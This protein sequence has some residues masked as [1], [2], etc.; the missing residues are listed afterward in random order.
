MQSLSHIAKFEVL[1]FFHGFQDE[2]IDNIHIYPYILL[3]ST[4]QI[5]L[6]HV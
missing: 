4:M 2:L 5:E 6:K 3:S 1:V